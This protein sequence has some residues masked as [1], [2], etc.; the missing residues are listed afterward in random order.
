MRQKTII[1]LGTSFQTMG[2]V[3]SVVNV[4]RGAGL[5]DR[6]PIIYL[7]THRDGNAFQ[8]LG[9]ASLA[10][11]RFVGLLI[12]GHVSVVHAHTA[13]RASFWRKSLFILLAFAARRQVIVHIHGAEFM[14]FYHEE[15]GTV[16]KRF[17]R[18]IFNR[19]ARVVVLSSQWKSMISEIT[20]NPAVISIF[21]PIETPDSN[22]NLV[23]DREPATL[24][25]LGRLGRRKGVFLVL[26][27]IARLQ[28]KFARICLL[29]GGDGD[30]AGVKKRAQELAID[31]RVKILGWVRGQ[32]KQRLLSKASVYV[33]P[34]YAEGLPM[35]VLEAMAAGLP[36][37]STSVGG[38]PD[39]VTDG[40]EGVLVEPGDVNGLEEAVARLLQDPEL[41]Q[42]MGDA[43]IRKIGTTFS[44]EAVLP[45]L[46]ALYGGL[47]VVPLR[48]QIKGPAG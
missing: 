35:G 14:Q 47:G 4:Y 25:F 3:S 18:F 46:E 39:A 33:L 12:G 43:A 21:N 32:E 8:K 45:K 7:A 23:V 16:S 28:E 15:C 24:L 1:M 30:L 20:Q 44:A 37:V 2:G 19:A 13:S 31:E 36:V 34:S 38:V 41:R 10:L 48:G 9:I 11:I 5:F 6:W 29:C 17:V 22:S 27:V 40:A 26:E 42:R